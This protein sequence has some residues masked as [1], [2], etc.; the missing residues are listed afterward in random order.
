MHG[1]GTKREKD[2]RMF[3]VR[4]KMGKVE[5]AM[6]QTNSTTSLPRSVTKGAERAF[7]HVPLPASIG[8]GGAG[9]FGTTSSR[10]LG[11]GGAVVKFS[12]VDD[13]DDDVGYESMEA[14]LQAGEEEEGPAGWLKDRW[15]DVTDVLS[16]GASRESINRRGREMC[17]A[18]WDTVEAVDC[19][20][21]PSRAGGGR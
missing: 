12:E 21:G 18:G 1:V 7:S 16:C 10:R 17:G 19:G 2:G 14:S 13:D 6:P 5:S 9:G 15:R 8:G 11:G 4:Y 3:E 20:R